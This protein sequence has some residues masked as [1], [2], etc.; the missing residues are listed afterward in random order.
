M[1]D[2]VRKRLLVFF[3]PLL[4]SLPFLNRAYF[5]DDN[6][7]VE[8]AHWLKDHPTQ[9]YHFRTDDAGIQNRGWEENGFV[10]MVN[11]LAHQYYL[12]LLMKIGGERTWFLRF[13]CV[14]LTCFGTLFLFALARRWTEHPL[15]ATLLVLVTP[16]SWLTAHSLLID[17]TLAFFALGAVYC[18]VRATETDSLAQ[19]IAS[20]VFIGLAILTKY[21]G[22]FLL[23]LTAAWLLL[24]W[25]KLSRRWLFAI[26]WVIGLLFLAG[27]SWYTQKLYGAP[28]IL[29]ASKRM[30]HVFGWPKLIVFFTFFSGAIVAPVLAWFLPVRRKMLYAGLGAAVAIVMASS[31]GGFS[32]T[33]GALMGFWIATSFLF[34]AAFLSARSAWV[35]PRDP[36]LFIWAIGFIAMMLIVMDWVA[37]RYY[38]LVIPAVGLMTVR[39]AEIF[40]REQAEPRIATLIGAVFVLSASLAYA[41]YRQAEPARQV[42]AALKEKGYEGGPR[43]FYLG[44]SFTMSYLKNDGWVPCFPETVF[45]PGDLVLGKQVTM[46]LV[47][48]YRRPIEKVQL[49]E[50]TYPSHFPLKVMDL[51]GS[52]G[53]YASVWGALPFTFSNAPWERFRLYRVIKADDEH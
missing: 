4:L 15:L 7:F 41:D 24:R 33:Q 27:Y 43:H 53:F 5:V 49:E 30:V 29:A 20:G 37:A 22:V 10:R 35:F 50:F 14:L 9:P 36:F 42:G 44:D 32:V 38:A 34:F 26:P 45:Q 16:V 23:P 39:L 13:G 3:V 6:Y 12:A 18:Y 25:K 8:I 17:S 11:P 21:P 31:A 40:W 19:L 47:W 52:A 28:H 48:F 2:L 46:P 51:R 1:T